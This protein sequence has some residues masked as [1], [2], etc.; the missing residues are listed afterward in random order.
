M[1]GKDWAPICRAAKLNPTFLRDALERET[2]PQLGNAQKLTGALGVPL[3]DWFL[4]GEGASAQPETASQALP[5]L[6]LMPRNVPVYGS[7]Q[8]G[9]DGQFEFNTGDIIDYLKRPPRLV[10]IGDAYALY[11]VG[12]SMWPWRKNG[13]PV[14]VHPRQP[15]QIEDFVVVQLR[16]KK[17]GEAPRALVKQLIK[18]TPKEITLQQFEPRITMTFP[19]SQ[20]VSIHRV[21]DWDELMGG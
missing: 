18:R 19:L 10:G 4:E 5:R 15:V 7:A 2:T 16:P 17:Q 3:T 11:L 13:A 9:E 6:D 14:Y 21:V 12:Q 8:C 20:V 1:A